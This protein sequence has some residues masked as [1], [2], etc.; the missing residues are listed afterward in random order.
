MRAMVPTELLL[1][2]LQAT[3]EQQIAIELILG[4]RGSG[5]GE[6]TEPEPTG[7][8]GRHSLRQAGCSWRVVFN[9]AAEFF[10]EDTLGVRYLDHLLRHPNKPIAAFDLEVLVRTE[11]EAARSR[12][13]AG[14]KVDAQAVKSYLRELNALR[15]EQERA[16]REGNG[17]EAQRLA[18]EIE[19]IEGAL[20]GSGGAA[21]AG[22]RG[23]DNVRKAIGAVVRK[24]QRGEAG[25]RA[26][27]R[28]L[29]QCLSLGYEVCYVCPPGEG[30]E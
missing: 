21:D 17:T 19:R 24:L 4:F 13:A 27:G 22:Q 9:G 10:V 11:K 23:R 8:R 14:A 28:H 29:R 25:A 6:R 20:Q 30:W 7:A 16:A 2:F 5:G 18:G 26:F 15:S 3:P 1:R 12:N